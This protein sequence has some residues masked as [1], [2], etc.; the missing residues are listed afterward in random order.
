MMVGN[1]VQNQFTAARNWPFGS[2]VSFVM[3]GVVL[4]AVLG[5]LR[6]RERSGGGI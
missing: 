1:L 6:T 5:Y 2:A 3:M 4:I